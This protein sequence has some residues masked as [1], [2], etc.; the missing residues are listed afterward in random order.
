MGLQVIITCQSMQAHRLYQMSHSG[1][2]G[3]NRG[4]C[5]CGEEVGMWDICAPS[6]NFTVN[7]NCY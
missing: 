6:L 4:G 7:I 3:E 5:A 2:D 1:G